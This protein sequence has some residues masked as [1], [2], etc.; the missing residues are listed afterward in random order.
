MVSL[1]GALSFE[2]PVSAVFELAAG[3]LL[4]RSTRWMIPMSAGLAVGPS[5]SS[6]S[7]LDEAALRVA[8]SS[9][10]S[11]AAGGGE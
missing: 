5:G 6:S 4:V 3:L 10:E 8:A 2:P 9:S 11:P 7:E 1:P